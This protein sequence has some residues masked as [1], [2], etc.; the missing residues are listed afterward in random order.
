ML[1]Q[2]ST[3]GKEQAETAHQIAPAEGL[4]LPLPPDEDFSVST[5]L[6]PRLLILT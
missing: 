3:L 6:D 1:S 2:T 5:F 4:H